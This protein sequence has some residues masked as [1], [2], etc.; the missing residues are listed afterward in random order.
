MFLRVRSSGIGLPFTLGDAEVRAFI[1]FHLAERY[2][3]STPRY[4]A[5]SKGRNAKLRWLAD[6][7]TMTKSVETGPRGEAVDSNIMVP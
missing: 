7:D 1:D 2:L 5:A 6:T 3:G 4:G